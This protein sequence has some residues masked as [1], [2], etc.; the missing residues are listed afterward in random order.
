MSRPPNSGPNGPS[1][2]R[3]FA[4]IAVLWMLVLISALA[5]GAV[6]TSHT[7]TRLA[8][9]VVAAAQARHLADGGILV[10]AKQ[11][12]ES[13]DQARCLDGRRFSSVTL[14]QS[15]VVIWVH[16]EA[17]KVD[18]NQAAQP[19]LRGLFSAAGIDPQAADA[20]AD[21]VLDWRDGD[22]EVRPHGAEDSDYR[23]LKL[24]YG[25][26]DAHFESSVDG[27]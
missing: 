11:L 10:G 16:D 8:T 6:T 7:E 4:L 2:H 5:V 24:G 13:K 12:V 21:A 23:L 27:A 17:G 15:E 22:H 9:N 14:D 1:R 25:A 20:L 3:G 26:K 18:L 19:L